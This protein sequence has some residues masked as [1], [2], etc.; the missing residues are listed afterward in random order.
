[1]SNLLSILEETPKFQIE[2]GKTI[3][4]E[5]KPVNRLYILI[6]GEVMITKKRTPVSHIKE[7]GAVFGE[8]SALLNGKATA[9]VTTATTCVFHIIEDTD[10]FFSQNN[11]ALLEIAKILAKRLDFVTHALVEE[12][13][14]NNSSYWTHWT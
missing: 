13:D 1:M 6:D 14:D 9:S 7:K 2:S 12:I 11:E 4:R 5:E 10:E 8:V 3:I